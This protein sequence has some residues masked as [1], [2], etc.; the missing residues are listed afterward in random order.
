MSLPEILAECDSKMKKTIDIMHKDF[1]GIRTGKASPALVDSIIVDYYGTPTPIKSLAGISIPEPRMMVITPWDPSSVTAVSKAITSANVG[2]N[3]VVDGKAIRLP[4]PD[5]SEER[6]KEL[7]KII[8]KKA[9]DGKIAVR[10]IRRDVNDIIKKQEKDKLLTED[11]KFEGE[12]KVQE[13]T[14]K[15]IKEIDSILHK[16]EKEIL[17]I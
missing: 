7:I 2:I 15:Y 5:L 13:E 1:S 17:E 12:K 9:E 14:D 11:D 6:R 8:K 3:P 10:N 16:K 4:V